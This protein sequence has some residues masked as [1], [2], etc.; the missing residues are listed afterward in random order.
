MSQNFHVNE[1][2]GDEILQNINDGGKRTVMKENISGSAPRKDAKFECDIESKY[3][4]TE[5][6]QAYGGTYS[7]TE[8]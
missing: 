7:V 4:Q 6:T 1:K 8:F 2:G 3:T 5:H